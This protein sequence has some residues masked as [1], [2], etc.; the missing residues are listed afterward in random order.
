MPVTSFD[1]EPLPPAARLPAWCTAL[2][3]FAL[4]PAMA[5]DDRPV[6][7]HVAQFRSP[8]G[9]GF[10]TIAAGAQT[11]QPIREAEDDVWWVSMIT[12]GA[13][14]LERPGGAIAVAAGDLLF[15]RRG[16]PEA[17]A[18]AAPFRMA[19]AT[20]P[21]D[22]LRRA[23]P[24]TL[25]TEVVL[26]RNAPGPVH[27][28]GAMLAAACDSIAR[29]DDASALAMETALIQLLLAGLFDDP[30]RNPLGGLAS[31]RAATLRRVCRTIEEHLHEP[32]IS[33][34]TIAAVHRMSVRSVQLLFE[35]SGNTFRGYVRMRRL[36]RARET[37]ADPRHQNLSITEICFH[38]GFGDCASFSRAFRDG[39]GTTPSSY[40]RE[41][42]AGRMPQGRLRGLELVTR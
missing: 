24:V 7:G 21:A 14:L 30:A 26:L 35:E 28:L 16:A 40:R 12:D 22:L 13:S 29:L 15:G 37:L 19:M 3:D 6:Q 17:L 38:W 5:R 33:P 31:A 18:I 23:S 41:A 34:A 39:F 9:I 11:L 4:R 1:T 10:T 20:I 25:P 2:T 32:E 27:V 8:R 36:E 42:L